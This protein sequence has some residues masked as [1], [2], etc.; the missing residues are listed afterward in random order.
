MHN[1]KIKFAITAIFL[2]GTLGTF[3]VFA[4]EGE[5]KG[6]EGMGGMMGMMSDMSP[7]DQEA[8]TEACMKMMQSHG[9][10]NMDGAR[11]KEGAEAS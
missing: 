10:D 8:M 9:S 5:G 1:S 3:S 6:M 7:E 2:A 11:K 4:H